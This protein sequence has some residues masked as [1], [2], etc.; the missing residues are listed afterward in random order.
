MRVSDNVILTKVYVSGPETGATLEANR[1]LRDDGGITACSHQ[2]MDLVKDLGDNRE[3]NLT[4]VAEI[5]RELS[6]M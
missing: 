5:I 4:S 3:A 1:S 2:V 6:Y